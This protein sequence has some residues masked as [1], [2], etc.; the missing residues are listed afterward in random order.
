MSGRFS[1][2]LFFPSRVTIFLPWPTDDL[3]G[4]GFDVG[5]FIWTGRAM[6]RLCCMQI[7]NSNPSGSPAAS[8]GDERR[9]DYLRVTKGFISD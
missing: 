5:S 7:S 6:R 9:M 2:P 1:F 4:P 8:E 3:R